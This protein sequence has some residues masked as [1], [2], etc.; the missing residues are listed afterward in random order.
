MGGYRVQCSKC[1]NLSYNNR[2]CTLRRVMISSAAS[3]LKGTTSKEGRLLF[4]MP[5]FGNKS[6]PHDSTNF[7]PSSET[8]LA[9][10]DTPK[11]ARGRGGRCSKGEELWEEVELQQVIGQV[12]TKKVEEKAG[13]EE[14]V[15][16][17]RWQLGFQMDKG[18]S[19]LLQHHQHLLHG[20]EKLIGCQSF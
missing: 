15:E 14:K 17:R 11:I 7:I 4:W 10:S 18:V 8:P 13:V 1:H 16:A 3:S 20:L 5:R 6:T 12:E 2:K 19:I 9:R